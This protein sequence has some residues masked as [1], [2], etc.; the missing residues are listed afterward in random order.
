MNSTNNLSEKVNYKHDPAIHNFSAAQQILPFL[1]KLT[2]VNSFIDIGCGTGTWLAVAK[3][4]GVK[5][6]LGVDGVD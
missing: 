6:I 3:E 1:L 5:E 4:L 2:P